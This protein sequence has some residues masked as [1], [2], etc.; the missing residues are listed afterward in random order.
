MLQTIIEYHKNQ[1]LNSDECTIRPIIDYIKNKGKLRE[2]Q[3]EAF[4]TYLFLKIKGQ[5]KPLWELFSEGFFS[6]G[7]DLS[8][9]NINQTAREI[10]E[11]NKAA[12]SLLDFT[13]FKVKN[14]NGTET[15]CLT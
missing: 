9:L 13:R 2:A 4:E 15:C 14:G 11:K 6:N 10:F 7:D 1:G 12:K 8:K 3:Y 5:N